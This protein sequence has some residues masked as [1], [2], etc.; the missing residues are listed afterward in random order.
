MRLLYLHLSRF[1]VQ[2]KVIEQPALAGRPFVLTALDRG[3]R[4]VSFSSSAALRAGVRTA[5][6]LTAA[7]ARVPELL[8][9]EYQPGA[10]VAAL[11]SLGEALLALG[12]GFQLSA[13]EGLWVDAAAAHL[14]GG[15]EGLARRAIELCAA[16]GYRAR[17][18][19]ASTPFTSRAV[20]RHGRERWVIV[21]ELEAARALAPLPLSALE[22]EAGFDAGRGLRELGALGL[23]TLGEVAALPLGAVV[24]RLGAGGLQAMRL[25]RGEDASAFVPEV[26]PEQVHEAVAL[27]WPAESLEPVTFAL[28]TCLDRVAFRLRGRQQAAVKLAIRLKLDPGGQVEIPLQLSRPTAHP[29]LLLDLAKHRLAEVTVP[30]PIAWVGVTVDE[31]S[32]DR[33]QQLGLGDEPEGDASLEVVLARLTST[34]G[35]EALFAAELEG[36]HKPERAYAQRPFRPPTR[37][38]GLLSELV[39]ER[40][41]EAALQDLTLIERPARLFPQPAPLEAETGEVGELRAARL[42]GKRRRVTAIAGPERLCG[43][44]WEPA[45]F[46]RDYYRVHFEGVGAA[47]VFRDGRDGR[48]YLQGM[49]D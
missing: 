37:E 8:H 35:E 28:K 29:K 2:R 30:N 11:V 9:F 47:W 5:M 10:E 33:G 40:A 24:A 34:L 36:V 6:T 16:H 41:P 48:F 38:R 14:V 23:S 12:P 44:W 7:S 25:C 39:R 31:A 15:E 43:E 22:L 45:P 18:A 46:S 17:A 32:A 19:L 26:L 42:L 49:F 13:P 3:V 27:E 20:A 4:R 21:P 1:P